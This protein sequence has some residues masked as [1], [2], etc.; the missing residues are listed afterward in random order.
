M[1][2]YYRLYLLL[3]SSKHAIPDGQHLSVVLVDVLGR[4]ASMMYSVRRW[5]HEYCG[6]VIHLRYEARVRKE[7]V[8]LFHRENDDIELRRAEKSKRCVESSRCNPLDCTL[9]QINTFSINR[10]SKIENFWVS[11]LSFQFLSLQKRF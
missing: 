3:V 4:S 8:N 2:E 7:T 9:R 6:N 11:L 1:T 5:S 10:R